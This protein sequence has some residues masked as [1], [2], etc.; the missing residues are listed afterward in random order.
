MPAR[1][2]VTKHFRELSGIFLPVI[3]EVLTSSGAKGGITMKAMILSLTIL[4]LAGG[5]WSGGS[6]L[7]SGGEGSGGGMIIQPA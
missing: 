5:E 3:G 6:I 4:L 2:I 1:Q 7:I